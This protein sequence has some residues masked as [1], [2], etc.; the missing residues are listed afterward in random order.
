MASSQRPALKDLLSPPT[1]DNQAQ[2]ADGGGEWTEEKKDLE[3][4]PK[5]NITPN[6]PQEQQPTVSILKIPTSTTSSNDAHAAS[7]M[8]IPPH[9]TSTTLKT[10]TI[11]NQSHSSNKLT[12]ASNDDHK[13]QTST[14]NPITKKLG[15]WRVMNEALQI[16]LE[17]RGLVAQ[18]SVLTE[19]EM[20]LWTGEKNEK[21]A[22]IKKISSITKRGNHRRLSS[23]SSSTG[24]TT[25]TTSGYNRYSLSSKHRFSRD[26]ET[27]SNPVN[28]GAIG[29]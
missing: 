18:G 20:K 22:I 14:R 10:P 26:L 7:S 23:T 2:E 4:G 27:P 24:T 16:G 21:E 13:K 28:W 25:T 5:K 17:E 9:P 11:S 12:P 3:N 15:E 8:I 6:K 1:S 19:K 29:E